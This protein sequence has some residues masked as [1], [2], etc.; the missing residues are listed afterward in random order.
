MA[1][2]LRGRRGAEGARHWDVLL[3]IAAGGAVGALGRW[4]LDRLLPGD[5]PQFPWG[6][7]LVNVAGSALLGGL[8]VL[9]VEV[10]PPHR[11]ARPFS[12]V[13]L[14]GG[15]TTFSTVMAQGRALFAAGAPELA[16]A[17]VVGTLVAALAAAWAGLALVRHLTR[18]ARQ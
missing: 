8:L 15:F 10:W 6:T 4:A 18:G 2:G 12:G 1:S 7:F 16:A 17:Y 14:L 9:L 11:Y 3:V 13:G 5:P